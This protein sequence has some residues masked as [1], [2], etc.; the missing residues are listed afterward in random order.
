M[1]LYVSSLQSIQIEKMG[2]IQGLTLDSEDCEA[3]T[4]RQHHFND[5][6]LR[7]SVFLRVL[8]GGVG[9]HLS[10]TYDHC[11]VLRCFLG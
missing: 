3:F 6:N 1:K 5:L 9:Y 11:G 8:T 10:G 2:E 4:M 7:Y